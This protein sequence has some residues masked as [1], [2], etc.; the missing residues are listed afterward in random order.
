MSDI[1]G[2]GLIPSPIDRR[3]LLM[4]AF[5]PTFP[6]PRKK[7]YTVQMTK[8][9]DQGQE[10]ACVG[11]ATAVGVREFQEKKE[12]NRYIV[13]SPRFLY[14]EA[15]KIDG[16]PDDEAGTSCLAAMKVLKEKG[17]C[18]EEFWPYSVEHPGRPKP[19]VEENA[20]QYRIKGYAKLDS[21]ETMKRSLIVNGPF[22]IGVPVYNNWR[23]QAVWETGKVPMPPENESPVGGH[24]LCVV[25]YD[26]DTQL[27]KFKNSWGPDWGDEGYGYL[28]Y[29]YM[30]LD[31]S[32][33]WSAT[34]LIDN[35]ETLVQAKERVLKNLGVDYI[36]EES[37]E[38]FETSSQQ[39][40]YH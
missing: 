12:H 13:L 28:P 8:V 38:G 36:E 17:V 3:T 19:G 23:T 14:E 32:E 40:T 2:L 33:A 37:E 10:G 18:E 24:A 25:G 30:N 4:S 7:D 29:Q 6:I 16:F 34:D 9:R 11:F 35:P 5:L 1:K 20:K 31:F 21:L 22:L 27:F 15:R 39:I 26:D